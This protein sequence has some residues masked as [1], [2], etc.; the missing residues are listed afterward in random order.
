MC[1]QHEDSDP[2][3]CRVPGVYTAC[4]P[5]DAAGSDPPGHGHRSHGCRALGLHQS[6]IRTGPPLGPLGLWFP[7]SPSGPEG[8]EDHTDAKP[9]GLPPAFAEPLATP[10]G[11]KET[12]P[13]GEQGPGAGRARCPRSG[14]HRLRGSGLRPSPQGP[15]LR[16]AALPCPC[17]N[18][19]GAPRGLQRER[20]PGARGLKCL[21]QEAGDVGATGQQAPGCVRRVIP[22]A[23][24]GGAAGPG[25]GD[26]GALAQGGH[27]PQ[28]SHSQGPGGRG[29][30]RRVLGKAAAAPGIPRV[31]KRRESR[32][33]VPT[34]SEELPSRPCH[35]RRAPRTWLDEQHGWGP[36][37]VALGP[38]G[39]LGGT[40]HLPSHQAST[41]PGGTM[42]TEE[43]T[44]RG[45]CG[46]PNPQAPGPQQSQPM[47][48]PVLPPPAPQPSEPSVPPPPAR[49]PG[50][51]SA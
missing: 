16:R 19:H 17:P 12:R 28:Q 34:G 2:P 8:W 18:S 45:R 9:P 4:S 47:Q 13:Q 32:Q 42:C 48:L 24:S 44:A 14:G 7:C 6:P 43:P 10:R 35:C 46:D 33:E 40:A 20:H 3:G 37:T 26:E 51:F 49:T 11:P 5:H 36:G 39:A 25:P 31:S 29:H 15:G 30:W 21:R 50:P 38:G 41:G 27:R 23:P 22:R 1:P